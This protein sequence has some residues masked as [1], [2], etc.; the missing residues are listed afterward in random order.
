MMPKSSDIASAYQELVSLGIVEL[1][2]HILDS[3]MVKK[4]RTQSGVAPFAVMMKPYPCPGRCVF[5]VEEKGLPK[6][7]MADEP[8]SARALSHN[9][10]PRKQIE[11]RL[12]Q[13]KLTGHS[14]QK[15]QIIVVGGTFSAY[16]KEY[17]ISFLKGIFDACKGFVAKDINEAKEEN[18]KSVHRVVGLS[19]ET[20]PDWIDDQE[21]KLL[22]MC[23]VTKV[24]LGVQSLSEEINLKSARGHD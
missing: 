21:I 24:Q 16:E 14:P 8:A 9:F 17:K 18:E 11:S 15:L 20:R 22:R 10:D 7:Y 13:M 3:L 19:V 23:G 12:L 4:V 2:A 1:D 5:C 6:S